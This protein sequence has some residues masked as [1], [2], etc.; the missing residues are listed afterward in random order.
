MACPRPGTLHNAGNT[1]CL[2]CRL[3]RCS[4]SASGLISAGNAARLGDR[5]R[6][7][8]SRFNSVSPCST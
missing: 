3:L 2:P 6:H 7:W 1:R 8:S 4:H 5:M